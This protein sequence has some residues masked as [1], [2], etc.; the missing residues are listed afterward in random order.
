MEKKIEMSVKKSTLILTFN[1]MHV[2][3]E[4]QL[5]KFFS[6]S[7]DISH[8][9]FE[10]SA[11]IS[12]SFIFILTLLSRFI[13]ENLIK[14]DHKLPRSLRRYNNTLNTQNWIVLQIVIAWRSKPIPERPARLTS[15]S[16]LTHKTIN[17]ARTR[18]C[19]HSLKQVNCHSNWEPTREAVRHAILALKRSYD[20]ESGRVPGNKV[21]LILKCNLLNFFVA[22]FVSD[23]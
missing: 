20:I 9:H 19:T 6:Q 13:I 1:N 12:I 4:Y 5:R 23:K 3:N 17:R 22:H 14:R 15:E 2:R 7:R 8:T 18:K 11:T 10:N 16:A 21:V